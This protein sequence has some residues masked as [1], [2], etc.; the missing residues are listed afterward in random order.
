LSRKVFTLKLSFFLPLF[1]LFLKSPPE[2]F[3][4]FL[5]AVVLHEAGHLFLLFRC[6][7]PTSSLSL[8]GCG[9][10]I[11]ADAPYLSY[12]KEIRVFLAGPLAGLAG[13]AVSWISLRMRFTKSGMLFFSFNLL[14]TLFNLLPLKGLD[15]GGALLAHLCRCGEMEEARKKCD[16]VHTV[17][18]FFLILFALWVLFWQKNASLLITALCLALQDGEKRKKATNVS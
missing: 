18:L 6:G 14:L 4:L 1:L 16:T 2:E 8:S 15:G 5:G 10:R 13:V 11:E 9:A 7:V 3:L 12:K 17:T